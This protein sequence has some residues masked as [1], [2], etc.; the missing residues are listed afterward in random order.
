MAE[1]DGDE[2]LLL[3][4]MLAA[5]RLEEAEA[6]L[7]ERIWDLLPDALAPLWSPL[8][9]CSPL[10]LV[11]HPALLAA[12]LRL[13]PHRDRSPVSVRA[14]RAARE[15]R[16]GEQISPWA[17]CGELAHA[18]HRALYAGDRDGMID[19]YTR[20]R[21]LIE[22]LVGSD[23]IEDAGGREVSELMFLADTVFRSGNTNPAAEIARFVVRVIEV[24]PYRLDPRGE[25]LDAARRLILHDHR[26][27]G[28]E[29]ILDASV[30]L[31]GNQFLRHDGDIVVAAMIQMWQ[32][33]DDGEF[34]GADAHLRAAAERI[35]DPGSW[36]IL[37]LMRAHLAVHR[38]ATEEI[39]TYVSAFE[40]TTLAT[41]GPFAQQAHSQIQRLA[42]HLSRHTGHAVPSP[43]FLPVTPSPCAPFSPRIEFTVHLMEALYAV[44]EGRLPEVRTALG[45]AAALS[46]RR[47]IGLYTLAHATQDEVKALCTVAED[48]PGAERLH[49]ERA[50]R[51]AGVLDAPTLEISQREREVLGHLRRGVTNPEMAEAMFV[52]V[53]T[54]K[55][56]RANLMR[57]LGASHRDELLA[58]AAVR[59]L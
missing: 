6:L 23:A 35:A 29:D 52:S 37:Q 11:D 1:R 51:I 36:R 20:V 14:A 49:L 16:R 47:E 8:M 7:R 55:F 32:V 54:V 43:G 15:R 56:H 41:A 59:G 48:V 44:R 2:E 53:N 21:A 26:G 42:D 39:Q 50:L 12:R 18:L 13:G 58:A 4:M 31:A 27:R 40:R 25:R 34:E 3:S 9:R 33:M 22:D 57:K 17:R 30:L 19:L 28:L 5:G 38:R 45:R 10:E 24:G 46:P